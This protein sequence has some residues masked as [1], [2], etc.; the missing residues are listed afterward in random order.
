MILIFF[1]SFL[2]SLQNLGYH[3]L[4]DYYLKGFTAQYTIHF[5]ELSEFQYQQAWRNCDWELMSSNLNLITEENDQ[6]GF[7]KAVH[8][9]LRALVE[10][11][12]NTLS[13]V[14][15]VIKLN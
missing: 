1:Q 12:A 3:H 2:C 9:A 7:H 5:P 8:C 14:L 11:D 10:G 15:Q 6:M 13:T 4:V